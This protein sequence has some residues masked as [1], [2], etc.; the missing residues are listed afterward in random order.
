MLVVP[1]A[2]VAPDATLTL[3]K[4]APA[5]LISHTLLTPAL[6]KEYCVFPQFVEVEVGLRK[7][8][9]AVN[10]V[11]LS[12]DISTRIELNVGNAEINKW[13][14][15]AAEQLTG[16]ISTVPEDAPLESV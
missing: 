11:E 15:L 16:P 5:R 6:L 12:G 7:F 13:A 3:T 1:A 4:D 8:V 10:H 14:S 2:R 9:Q